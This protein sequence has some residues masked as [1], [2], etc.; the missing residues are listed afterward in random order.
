[1]V[2]KILSWSRPPLEEALLC[3]LEEGP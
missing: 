3:T 1:L 2:A